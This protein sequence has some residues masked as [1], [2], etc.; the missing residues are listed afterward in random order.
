MAIECVGEHFNLEVGKPMFMVEV[1]TDF[2]ECY[3]CSYIK[4]NNIHI[5][6]IEGIYRG[7]V[8]SKGDVCDSIEL[9]LD[10][11]CERC[12]ARWEKLSF[13]CKKGST[14]L[15]TGTPFVSEPIPV[16]IPQ[17]VPLTPDED[18]V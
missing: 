7:H 9:T 17:L 6:R 13:T 11:Y 14:Y 8:I 18:V 1:R 4:T 2:W 5:P 10:H 15:V 16:E 3:S 12:N